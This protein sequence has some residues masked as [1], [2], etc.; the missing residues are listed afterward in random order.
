LLALSSVQTKSGF[1]AP[2]SFEPAGPLSG[3]KSLFKFL[4]QSKSGLSSVA[5]GLASLP[6]QSSKRSTLLASL[7]SLQAELLSAANL[8]A[9]SSSK[10]DNLARSLG[11]FCANTSKI[12]FLRTN[13][14]YNKGRYSRNRQTYRTGA[15][16]CMWLTVLSVIGLYFYF[17]VFLIKFTY[18]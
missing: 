3:Y 4:A 7:G 12:F 8:V 13:E 16:W 14:L 11:S 1:L 17:Y 10:P 9:S 18:V 6:E 15:Y 2:N 5:S